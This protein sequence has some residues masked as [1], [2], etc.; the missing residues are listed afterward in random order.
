MAE[1]IYIGDSIVDAE[2]KVLFDRQDFVD[3]VEQCMGRDAARYLENLIETDELDQNQRAQEL[4]DAYDEGAEDAWSHQDFEQ[5][6]NGRDD[7]Y[8]EGWANGYAEGYAQ[9]FE[10][11]YKKHNCWP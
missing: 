11:G 1:T 2:T 4:Q 5:Y 3:L 7:G 6:N 8:E 10:E 9:G